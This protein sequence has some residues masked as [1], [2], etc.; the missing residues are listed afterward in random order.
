MAPVPKVSDDLNDTW[1]NVSD[2]LN[3]TCPKVSDDLNDT[4]SNA[5]D[6]STDRYSKV[7][8]ICNDC[9]SISLTIWK[10]DNGYKNYLFKNAA[11]EVVKTCPAFTYDFSRI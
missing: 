11:R 6:I 3:G 1:P 8:D 9:C 5:N 10:C 4:C 7:S 2:D